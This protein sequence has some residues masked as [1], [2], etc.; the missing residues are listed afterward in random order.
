MGLK[1][2]HT[3]PYVPIDLVADLK[4]SSSVG[5]IY[6]KADG[7][8]IIF[9]LSSLRSAF[10][11]TRM[12]KT[13]ASLADILK[14]VDQALKWVDVTVFIQNRLFAILGTKANPYLLKIFMGIY[15]ISK[16]SALATNR[17][18]SLS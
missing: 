12:I 10:M 6:V 17:R 4:V 16:L 3:D 7:H 8:N 11:I 15:K 18:K 2:H 9:R 1:T 5:K 13:E 14:M